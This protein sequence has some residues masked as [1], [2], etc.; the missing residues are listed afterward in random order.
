MRTTL[1]IADDVLAAARERARLQGQT[2]GEVLSA[3]ARQALTSQPNASLSANSKVAEPKS[4]CGF[5]PFPPRGGVVTNGLID[6]LRDD[7]IY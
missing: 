2:L 7:G 1:D 5:R 3:L 6:K 4:I